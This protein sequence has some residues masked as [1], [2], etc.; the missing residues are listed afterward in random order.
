LFPARITFFV[1]GFEAGSRV[2][3]SATSSEDFLADA[4]WSALSCGVLI[5]ATRAREGETPVSGLREGA[6]LSFVCIILDDVVLGCSL[7]SIMEAFTVLF[8][9]LRTS[10]WLNASAGD[11]FEMACFC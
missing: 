4:A 9:T 6:L 1:P 11:E 7:A 3:G 8:N 2:R 5:A 10:F